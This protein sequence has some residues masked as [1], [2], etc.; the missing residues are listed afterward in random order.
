[1]R[2]GGRPH[3]T[4]TVYVSL[5]DTGSSF[6]ASAAQEACRTEGD[7]EAECLPT[8]LNTRSPGLELVLLLT[9]GPTHSGTPQPTA[10][11]VHP[12]L[13]TSMFDWVPFSLSIQAGPWG[14]PRGQGRREAGFLPAPP[15]RPAAPLQW[16]PNLELN[17][18]FSLRV[19]IWRLNRSLKMTIPITFQIEKLLSSI[20]WFLHLW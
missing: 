3:L 20:T 2:S 11:R 1:M 14:W 10:S 9:Q 19:R 7:A 18:R 4:A 17:L 12:T 13:G 6:G 15:P 16:F 5:G 8:V